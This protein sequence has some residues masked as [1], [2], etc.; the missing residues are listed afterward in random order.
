MFITKKILLVVVFSICSLNALVLNETPVLTKISTSNWKVTFSV[1]AITDVAVSIV[2]VSDS[3]VVRHLAAGVLGGL[4]PPPLLKDSLRQTIYW[5]GRNDRG[6]LYGGN[7]S[8]LRVRVRAGMTTQLV[9]LIGGEPYSIGIS[10]TNQFISGIVAAS[11]GS[12]YVAG[13]PAEFWHEHYGQTFITVRK[14]DKNGTYVKTVFPIPS[15]LSVSSASKWGVVDNGDGS[16]TPKNLNTSL[17]ILTST[18]LGYMKHEFNS[19]LQYID[20]DQNI[21]FGSRNIMKIRPDGT[22]ADDGIAKNLMVTPTFTTSKMQGEANITPLK[23]GKLLLTGMFNIGGS[24]WTTTQTA[25]DTNFYRDGKV[26]LIDPATGTVSTWLSIDSVPQT[27]TERLAKLGGGA[28]YSALQGTAVDSIGKVYVCDR[29]HQRVAVYD[30]A[31]QYLGALPISHPHRVQ[32]CGRTGEVYVLTQTQAAWAGGC[33]NTV[34]LIKFA[35]V[36]SGGAPLCTLMITSASIGRSGRSATSSIA[37]NDIDGVVTVWIGV[38]GQGVRLYRDNGKT[39]SLIKDMKAVSLAE[40]KLGIENPTPDRLALDQATGHLYFNNSAYNLYKITDWSDPVTRICSTSVNQRL[41]A[42]DIAIG[43]N[44]LMYLFYGN[45]YNAPVR[46][47]TLDNKHAP[48]NWSNSGKNLLTPYVSS[49][50][51]PCSGMRGLAVAQNGDVAIMAITKAN[52]SLYTVGVYPDTGSSDTSWGFVRCS[53]IP[54]MSGGVKYDLKG[55]LYFG[56]GLRQSTIMAPAQFLSDTGFKWGVGSIIRYDGKDTGSI[57]GSILG[58]TATNAAKI[59]DFPMSPFS[60][61]RFGGCLCRSPRF[62]VDA[63]GRLFV[64]DAVTCQVSVGDNSGNMIHRFGKYGNIDSRGSLPGAPLQNVI[65]R[66]EIPFA[67]P[68][69]VVTSEDYMYVSDYM[70]YRIAKIKMVYTADNMPDFSSHPVSIEDNN[71]WRTPAFSL[72]SG[73]IP[74]SGSTTIGISLPGHANLDFTIYDA[75][76]R[77][78]KR[79]VNGHFGP[80]LHHFK[81]NGKDGNDRTLSA[82]LY[83]YRVKAGNHL[84]V[85]KTIIVK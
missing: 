64:P 83:V 14:F 40:N 6:D 80:G 13:Q 45:T 11:D 9:S 27:A 79:V 31:A 33:M 49:R 30:S 48:A 72:T 35:S 34:K 28:Y 85:S 52:R 17:P 21:V 70:N 61:D 82:G 3:T 84:I 23:N 43:P 42:S 36:A 16:Y 19:K 51:A 10:P 56:A 66:S 69:A 59:Y 62:D 78:V 77:L 47:F 53:P 12:V 38:W 55:N 76:G 18:I 8:N 46:R 24:S 73:P 25:P 26:F 2:D 81:W 44:N 5:D 58:T 75:K 22:L 37:V 68:T 74:F 67:W 20:R 65:N 41:Y 32:V 39:F 4:V 60:A 71:H 63:Y 7:E 1:D 57:A 29:L 15:N 54:G 50:A